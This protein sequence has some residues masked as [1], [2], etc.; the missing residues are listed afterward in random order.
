MDLETENMIHL[1][2]YSSI[3]NHIKIVH[4]LSFLAKDIQLSSRYIFSEIN[5]EY[6]YN[7]LANH[8]HMMVTIMMTHKWTIHD[9]INFFSN[10][11][12]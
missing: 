12:K 4:H 3:K 8:P 5:S 9:Y 11:A 10:Y 2:K 1:K 6:F 7:I